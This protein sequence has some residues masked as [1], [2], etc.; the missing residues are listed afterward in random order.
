MLFFGNFLA[1]V[2]YE[3]N[4]G[5][6]FFFFFF[7]FLYLSHPVL[8]KNNVRK[9]FL[10]FWIFMLYLSEFSCPGRVLTEFGTKFFLSFSAFLIPFWLKIMS[11]IG[12]L[13]SLFFFYFFQNFHAQV[14]SE[15]NSGLKVFS[16]FLGLSRPVLA[17][18]NARKCFF[19]FLNFLLF[20]FGIFL[21]GSSRN[22]MRD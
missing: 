19:N 11:E 9:R 16:R 14:E 8:A 3:L 10:N 4:S 7:V 22:G 2:K 1:R 5:Q 12:F 17:K 20:F 13:I 15:R 18:K 21:P 6:H